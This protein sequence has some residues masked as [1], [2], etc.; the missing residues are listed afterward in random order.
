[1][2]TKIL[3][4]VRN[5]CGLK[6]LEFGCE[7]K[8][9]WIKSNITHWYIAEKTDTSLLLTTKFGE[10]SKIS[11]LSDYEIIG[12]PVHLEHLLFALEKA[13]QQF[14]ID[15]CGFLWRHNLKETKATGA[16]DDTPKFDLQ[17][18]VEQNLEDP[19]LCKLLVE[20]LNIK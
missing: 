13:D 5:V 1:M 2:K 9:T 15:F 17:K 20:V 12:L 4:H 6:K 18:T 19:A 10:V 11:R 3:E 8:C 16:Y 7:I 14:F